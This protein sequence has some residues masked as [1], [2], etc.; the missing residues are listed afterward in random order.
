[1]YCL[2]L[3]RVYINKLGP[4]DKVVA[5]KIR[6][7]FKEIETSNGSLRTSDYMRYLRLRIWDATW[8]SWVLHA[9]PK[10]YPSIN[11]DY[12]FKIDKLG[13]TLCDD[14]GQTSNDESVLLTGVCF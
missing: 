12:V 2:P 14:C 10:F 8:C 9:F 13:A 6:E 4:P 5:M 11:D 7:I 1:M 3:F